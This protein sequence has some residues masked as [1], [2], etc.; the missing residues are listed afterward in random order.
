M[1]DFLE[2]IDGYFEYGMTSGEWR[3]DELVTDILNEGKIT[4]IGDSLE[5]VVFSFIASGKSVLREELVVPFARESW[6]TFALK[7]ER[8]SDMIRG[9][10]IEMT[11]AGGN[12]LEERHHIQKMAALGE[13]TTG[14]VHDLRNQLA[15]IGGSAELIKIL[16][17]DNGQIMKYTNGISRTLDNSNSLIE[18][19][20]D[21]SHKESDSKQ[22]FNLANILD[23]VTSL[24]G[25]TSNR[26]IEIVTS[27]DKQEH[28]IVGNPSL[29][30]SAILNLCTNARDAMDG[31]HGKIE[32][33][34]ARETV[35]EIP[36]DLLK[37]ENCAGKYSIL[38]V[39]DTGCGMTAD[40]KKEIFKPFFTTKE[41]GS[42]TGM[43]MPQ[44]LET[45]SYH[46]GSMTI[47]SEIGVGTEFALYLPAS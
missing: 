31:S 15:C 22:I 26:Y 35:T 10:L 4:E 2:L 13:L 37:Q 12:N 18:Q 44:V 28:R 3:G 38:R 23:D 1:G 45:I 46:G 6:K 47:K 11:S 25:R 33:S 39:K 34:L 5:D 9:V 16:C 8:Q 30:S 29:I 21:F 17:S 24:F 42:G 40:I 20:L 27:L 41:K 43:G 7:L 32:V 14:V 36:N 19:L